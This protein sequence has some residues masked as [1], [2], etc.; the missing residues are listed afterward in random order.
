MNPFTASARTVDPRVAR[1]AVR[2]L[3]KRFGRVQA[4]ADVNIDFHAGEIH[5]VLGENGA[6][7]STLM[8]VLDGACRPDVGTITLDGVPLTL[9]SS[10][11]AFAA[12]IGMVHQHF[13]LVGA[14]TIAENLALGLP[15]T[16]RWR[17]DTAAVA[18]E[19]MALAEQIGLDI[20]SPTARV[21]ELPVGV[22]QR[23]EIL[24]A[25]AGATRVLILDEPTAVLTPAEVGQLFARLRQLRN[26]DR[27]VIFITHKLREAKEIA[28]RVTIMRRGRVIVTTAAECI[29]E[30]EMAQRMVGELAPLAARP[31]VRSE[32]AL[33]VLEL[34]VY[35]DTMPRLDRVSFT[36]HA[37]E[38]FG[39]AGVDGNGQRE[40]FE[41]LVGLRPPGAGTVSVA[42]HD[43][44]KF[45][46]AALVAAGV[47]HVPPDRQRQGLVLPMS[48]ADNVL[49]SL[50]LRQRFSRHG[51]L[52]V[53][54]ARRFASDLAQQYA[55]RFAGLDAPL[56][57]LSG[58][59]QQRIVV[60]RALADQPVVLVAVNPTRGLDV[61]AARAIAGALNRVVE[62]GC[63]VVLISTDLDEVLE[64]SDRLSVLV[65]GRLSA[66]LSPPVDPQ[67]LGLLMAGAA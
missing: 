13:T 38:V 4:L 15:Q 66:S 8:H 10:R 34:S 2:G 12:G 42:G 58:G 28:D 53:T 59:N 1:L 31:P 61:A 27:A 54:A 65:R 44:D 25:L 19:A 62:G 60:A 11:D 67:R 50:A 49:L 33:R 17:L 7:K 47:A 9:R 3:G 16:S 35:H 64:L 26:D 46:P 40:L 29:S 14:L 36:V 52:D 57:S 39:I 56:R 51:L 55:V 20:G 30:D 43:L 63:A 24:K 6:G 23:V 37:G 45:T 41:V 18:A 32:V 21:G 48:V 5:A 22:R